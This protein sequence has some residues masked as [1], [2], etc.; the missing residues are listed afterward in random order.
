MKCGVLVILLMPLISFSQ[1]SSNEFFF[2]YEHR[3]P[4][5]Y[6]FSGFVVGTNY[7][8][9]KIPLLKKVISSEN[10]FLSVEIGHATLAEIPK[11]YTR[12]G[13]MQTVK[14]GYQYKTYYQLYYLL[15]FRI[16]AV[17]DP[18]YHYNAKRN[19]DYPMKS[20][21]AYG[22]ELMIGKKFN[23]HHAF[24]ADVVVGLTYNWSYE[25]VPSGNGWFDPAKPHSYSWLNHWTKGAL[26][27]GYQF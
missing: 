18:S 24:F 17:N 26:K 5:G 11:V 1:G 3:N 25:V 2:G 9:N 23:I 10:Y 22:P 4:K 15:R 13:S 20:F 8:I 16:D 7:Q 21:T 6:H 27:I 14:I 12:H 19:D